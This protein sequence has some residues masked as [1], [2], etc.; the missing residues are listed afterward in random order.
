MQNIDGQQHKSAIKVY[1]SNTQFTE[2]LGCHAKWKDTGVKSQ[3]HLCICTTDTYCM[4]LRTC[5]DP[6]IVSNLSAWLQLP[7]MIGYTFFPLLSH[8]LTYETQQVTW[9]STHSWAHKQYILNKP[10][11]CSATGSSMMSELSFSCYVTDY[12]N[13]I[14]LQSSSTIEPMQQIN[15]NFHIAVHNIL[16]R[17]YHHTCLAMYIWVK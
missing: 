9:Q 12:S 11:P 15:H 16:C 14:S 6:Y 4:Y 7:N 3:S 17:W 13:F 1:V 10:G 8:S 5:M 2:T